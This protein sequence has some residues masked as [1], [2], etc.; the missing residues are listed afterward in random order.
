M[1]LKSQRNIQ[2]REPCQMEQTSFC[3][4][5]RTIS[6]T[7]KPTRDIL[8]YMPII[9]SNVPSG[10]ITGFLMGKFF[11]LTQLPVIGGS[12]SFPVPTSFLKETDGTAMSLWLKPIL[13]DSAMAVLHSGLMEI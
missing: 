9:Q 13:Q 8:M 12:I 4:N 7:T 2:A 3:A 11:L 5:S 1:E 6:I 10:A